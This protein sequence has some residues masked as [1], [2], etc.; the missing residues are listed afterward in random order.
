VDFVIKDLEKYK[1][2]KERAEALGF[3]QYIDPLQN[4]IRELE[5]IAKIDEDIMRGDIPASIFR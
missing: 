2:A 5:R 4:I 1:K 3:S